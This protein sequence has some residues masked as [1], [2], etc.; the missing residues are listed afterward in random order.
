MTGQRLRS[1]GGGHHTKFYQGVSVPPLLTERL[2]LQYPQQED[3]RV[4]ILRHVANVRHE[5]DQF[6][7][8]SALATSPPDG[9]ARDSPMPGS[10]PGS[11]IWRSTVLMMKSYA[12]S[13]MA[14]TAS[15]T[16]PYAVRMTTIATCDFLAKCLQNL[17]PLSSRHLQIKENQIG[18][19]LFNRSQQFISG[20]E[21][22]DLMLALGQPLDKC[23]KKH[24]FIVCNIDASWHCGTS[25][26]LVRSVK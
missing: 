3:G 13:F 6:P 12:P 11:T 14:S 18:K 26:Y 16:V 7:A 9:V 15:S 24:G 22:L 10:R 2:I 21:G 8:M 17:D 5:P 20:L 1:N 23:V 4:R 19:A 25:F